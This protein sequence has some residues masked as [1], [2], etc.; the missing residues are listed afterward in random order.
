MA[1]VQGDAFLIGGDLLRH[2]YDRAVRR[3]LGCP[4]RSEKNPHVLRARQLFMAG[5]FSAAMESFP[6]SYRTERRMLRYMRQAGENYKGAI[7]RISE[8][9]RKIFFSAY[10]SS[11]FNSIL[12]T[13]LELSGG[14]PGKLFAG[15]LAYLHRNV[16]RSSTKLRS[17]ATK[18]HHLPEVPF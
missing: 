17:M 16:R 14:R 18:G 13:R 15:D 9:I 1:S 2:R 6:S 7:R 8:S 4:S 10:Q 11:L 12:A 3:I 5:D